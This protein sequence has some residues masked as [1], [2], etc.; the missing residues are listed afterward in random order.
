[1]QTVISGTP[2]MSDLLDDYGGRA[3]EILQ[4]YLNRLAA[5]G[6]QLE[7]LTGD[8]LDELAE[9]HAEFRALAG[10][11]ES[12]VIELPLDELLKIYHHK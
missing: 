2:L 4:G 5:A 6:N 10:L 12:I 8:E 9:I 3:A 11:R 7:H 1:M